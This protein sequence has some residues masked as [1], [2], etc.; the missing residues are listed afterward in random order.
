MA[1]DSM[2]GILRHRQ[3]LTDQQAGDT[4]CIWGSISGSQLSVKGF[5]NAPSMG[6]AMIVDDSIYI[7]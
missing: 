7:Y 5:K 6:E 3:E 1:A 4:G 2:Y